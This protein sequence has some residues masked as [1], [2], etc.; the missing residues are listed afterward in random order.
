MQEY[1]SKVESGLII[2][3]ALL[4]QSTSQIL[5]TESQQKYS[6]TQMSMSFGGELKSQMRSNNE[7]NGKNNYGM[8]NQYIKEFSETLDPTPPKS[9]D[10]NLSLNKH[11][12]IDK[13]SL[14]KKD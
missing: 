4:K 7:N 14:A 3:R 2:E 9:Y 11:K 10:N 13:L 5:R 6:G 1:E 8:R 12:K